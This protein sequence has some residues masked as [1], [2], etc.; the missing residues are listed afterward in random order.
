M[1]RQFARGQVFTLLVDARGAVGL[2]GDQR[3][4]LLAHMRET[5]APAEALLVQAIV[6]D[7]AL[8]RAFYFGLMWAIPMGFP[9]KPFA[10]PEPAREWLAI[11]L[12]ARLAGQPQG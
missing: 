6:L 10:E 11:Q 3:R 5:A 7:S 4:R 1:N 2:A 9:S 8:V 12:R